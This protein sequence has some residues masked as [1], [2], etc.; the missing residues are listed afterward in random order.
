MSEAA[1]QSTSKDLEVS[2]CMYLL[3][4]CGV[5]RWFSICDYF[6]FF[7]LTLFE[8]DESLLL[9]EYGRGVRQYFKKKYEDLEQDPSCWVHQKQ[10]VALW[11]LNEYWMH[12]IKAMG[13]VEAILEHSLFKAT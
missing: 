12:V 6:L 1:R 8:K 11:N 3:C 9:C 4:C 2:F 7:S 10:D 13:G 5:Q